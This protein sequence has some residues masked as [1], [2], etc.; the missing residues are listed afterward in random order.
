[1]AVSRYVPACHPAGPAMNPRCPSTPR[2]SP[3]HTATTTHSRVRPGSTGRT[4]QFRICPAYGA[5][6]E[7]LS[8][9]AVAGAAELADAD[10]EAEADGVGEGDVE[11]LGDGVGEG[12]VERLG[13]GLGDVDWLGDGLGDGEW[14]TGGGAGAGFG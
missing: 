4:G 7:D 5:G 13:D 12:D 14:L 2:R 11:R 8:L 1:M 3:C 10:A 9:E 6:P